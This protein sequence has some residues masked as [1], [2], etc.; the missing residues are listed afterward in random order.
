ME[1]YFPCSFKIIFAKII[2]LIVLF[3]DGAV[4]NAKWFEVLLTQ[5]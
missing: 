3:I 5:S 4:I 2:D 1:A